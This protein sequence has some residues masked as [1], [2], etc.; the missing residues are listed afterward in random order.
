[1]G[2]DAHGGERRLSRSRSSCWPPAGVGPTRLRPARPTRRRR[3]RPTGQRS[4]LRRPRRRRQSPRR[5][6]RSRTESRPRYLSD[7]VRS[8]W[9]RPMMRCG[10]SSTE[11]TSSARSTLPQAARLLSSLASRRTARWRWG[12]DTCGRRRLASAW[13]ARSIPIPARWSASCAFPRRAGWLSTTTICGSRAPRGSCESTRTRSPSGPRS[14][15]ASWSSGS[16]SDRTRCGRRANREAA[17]SGASIRART[18]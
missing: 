1:M 15:L 16:Q 8:R 7:R 18:R 11:R 17:R 6:R 13:S 2:H 9:P 5:P 4:L 12:T 10:W 3:A 14:R